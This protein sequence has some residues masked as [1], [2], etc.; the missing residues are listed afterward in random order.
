MIRIL[1]LITSLGLGGAEAT[2]AQLVARMDRTRFQSSVVVMRSFPALRRPIPTETVPLYCL[3]M[4]HAIPNPAALA[5]L[6]S[7][8]RAER[9]QVLQTWMYHADL[10][11]LVASRLVRIP[12]IVWNIRRSFV[13]MQEHK[14][15]TA[16]VLRTLAKLSGLPDVVLTNSL[17]GQKTHQA[18]GYDPRRWVWIPNCI[19]CDRFKPDSEQRLRL[20]NELGLAADTPLVGLVARYLPIKGHDIFIAAAQEL[21]AVNR[22]VHF[23]LAGRLIDRTNTSL[24]RSLY[25]R[26]LAGRFHL[27]GEREN[28]ECVLAG[29][30]VACSSSYGEGFPNTVGEAMACGVPCVVTDVGDSALLIGSTGKVVPAG[31]SLALYRSCEQLLSSEEQRR[32]FG[33][34]ARRRVE[35]CF[36]IRSMVTRYEQLYEELTDPTFMAQ[37]RLDN[38]KDALSSVHAG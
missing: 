6:I 32:H 15:I 37:N 7:V 11:G 10:L 12:R 31:N 14:I 35:D 30:D 3:Q 25:S 21:A 27:L 8:L 23:V 13:S 1:H 34:C 29:L 18:L 16:L 20:R 24:M 2:L 26:G 4:R 36:S 19:D 33:R 9:P 38:E 17:A 28:I 5:H 22:S